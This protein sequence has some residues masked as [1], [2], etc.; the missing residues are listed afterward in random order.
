MKIVIKTALSLLAVIIISGN[1]LLCASLPTAI[2]FQGQIVKS[3]GRPVTGT[4]N[5]TFKVYNSPVGGVVLKTFQNVSASFNSSGVFVVA[6]DFS[7]LDLNQN[8]WLGITIG[9]DTEMIPRPSILP[10]A[11]SIY[12]LSSV[13]AQNSQ[14]SDKL[15]GATA[16]SYFLRSGGILNGKLNM[17]NYSVLSSSSIEGVS[18]IVWADGSISTS[19]A[20]I[21]GG[22][23][24]RI[25]YDANLNGI[26]DDSDKL[27]GNIPS[28][29]ANRSDVAISTNTLQSNIDRHFMISPSTGIMA[30]TLPNTVKITTANVS[31]L[32]TASG[33]TFLRGDGNWSTP[34]GSGDMTKDV[35]DIGNN[36]IVDDSDKLGTQVP[37]YY[38][39]RADVAA[40]TGTLQ[41]NID[42]QFIVS[43]STGIMAGTLP[44]TVKI[45]TGNVSAIGTA[46]GTTFLR[47]DGSWNTPAGSGD[48]TKA[49]YDIGNNGIVDDSE[50]LGAQ[51]PSYYAIRTDV[52]VSTAT[53]LTQSSATVTYLNISAKAAGSSDSDK[54]DGNIPSY[55]ANR[56][57]VA[58]STS[59]FLTQSSATVTYLNISAKAAGSS[60]SD[61]LGGNLPSFYANRSDVAASTA[62]FLTAANAATI[63]LSTST[64]AALY[65][66]SSTVGSTYLTLS[67]ATVTY[68]TLSSATVTYLN[69]AGKA[70]GSS[71]S[72]KLGGNIPSYYANR[73]DVITSTSTFLTLSAATVTYLNIAGKAIG[74]SD[75]DQLGGNLPSYYANRLDVAI[76]TSTFLTQSSATVTYLNIAGKAAS[77]NNSDQLGGNIPS[78]YAN[79]SDVAVSTSTFLTQSSATV[80]YLNI[81]GKAASSSNSDQLGGNIPSYYANR[82]DV[83][84][85]TS[86]FLTQS[87][88]TVTY[89]NIAGKAIGSS[90]SDQL[91][92]NL[93]SYYADRLDVATST[94]TFL[95]QSSAAVTYLN[96][97][98]KAIGSSDSDQLGGNL[99]SY[100]AN[101]LDVAVSTNTLQ[102]NID[103][104][105]MVSPSTGIMAGTL[106]DTVKITTGNV[107]AIGAA[108]NT[109]FLRGDGTWG[110]PTGDMSYGE[111]FSN[112]AAVNT[113]IAAI[114]TFVK[115]ANDTTAGD[116]KN[117][118][119]ATGRLTYYGLTTKEFR[120]N[121]SLNA[122]NM[123]A[124]QTIRFSVAKNG[125]SL[126][127]SRATVSLTYTT[128]G[129]CV[130]LNCLTSLA[131]GDYIEV[132]T[133]NATAATVVTIADLNVVISS[134]E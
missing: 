66:T 101:R 89:L 54:L 129:Y 14:N 69:I 100:Y 20:S 99:P 76:S 80:T 34:A 125:I 62:T 90:D 87:S 79:R 128:D 98:G 114:E 67:S 39:S 131:T 94:S 117:F 73:S 103:K 19:A 104:Q 1:T 121:V 106:P 51:V 130:S 35:Y 68:L 77:S 70:A 11:T 26:V 88:A 96:I 28:Y 40:S 29:Y 18:K 64:A 95:T 43:P 4:M 63:F 9:A 44:N 10:S 59:T 122:Q 24:K 53:F 91:G 65:L 25:N 23:M 57:D 82:S 102:S 49:V 134:N 27:G 31:A 15:G 2:N 7:G 111:M 55:Y 56:S 48:M 22:D 92:G 50:K 32:G 5:V 86:T 109:T 47:G 46:S 36:G 110:T 17:N 97:A 83:A 41:L 105:F 133:A 13:N 45:T 8:L 124:A 132:F 115:I 118:T 85:S 113:T 37:S 107:S 112:G 81:A 72:D 3:N 126:P 108:S 78:Y 120:V 33:T 16:G 61:K 6:L 75:S 123:T 84:V 38:A 71:D 119:H 127:K 30:G 93:P 42:K 60:D 52:S 74:S 21:S 58:V 116:L 12:S